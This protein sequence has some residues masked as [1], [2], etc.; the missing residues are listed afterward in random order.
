MS[1][2]DPATFALWAE[3]HRV[4]G[5]LPD[6]ERAVFDLVWYQDVSEVEAAGVLGIDERTVRRLRSAQRHL[7]DRLGGRLPF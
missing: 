2:F 6:D 4:A 5:E 7:Y 3:F 1:T